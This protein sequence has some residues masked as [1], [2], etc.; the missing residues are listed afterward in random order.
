[1]NLGQHNTI[2]MYMNKQNITNREDNG[3]MSPYD[4][5]ENDHICG[6]KKIKG[7]NLGGGV[8]NI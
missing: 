2:Y 1:M 8:S 3:E 6:S 7:T 5:K 4:N